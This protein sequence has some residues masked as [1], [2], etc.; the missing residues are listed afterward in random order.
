M[1]YSLADAAVSDEAEQQQR[2]A[3]SESITGLRQI[4]GDCVHWLCAE[5]R[6]FDRDS[7]RSVCETLPRL[8]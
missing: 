6:S 4:S 7:R 2:G 1:A 8:L 5:V 3:W